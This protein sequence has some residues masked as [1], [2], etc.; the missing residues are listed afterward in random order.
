MKASTRDYY[1]QRLLNVID[2]IHAHLD[3]EL[4]VNTLADIACMSPYHFHRIYRR[5]VQEPV[6]ATVRRL[7]LQRAASE[8]IRSDLSITQIA[9]RVC[10]GSL[11]AFSRAF[12]K[13]FSQSPADY[14]KRHQHK[15]AALEPF[16][17]T[18]PVYKPEEITMYTTEIMEWDALSLVGY[19]HRGDY[20]D[21][22]KAFEKLFVSG[23]SQ[24][25]ISENTR[26]I[27]LYYDDPKSVAIDQLRSMAC[28]TIEPDKSDSVLAKDAELRPMTIP[29][30]RCVSLLFK[31]PYP[32]LE[33]PY[34]WL[35]GEWLPDSGYE[36]AD[37]PPFEEYL[38]DPRE[39]P[40]SELLTR[41]H[42]LLATDS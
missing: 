15:A 14:R 21:I 5:L 36:M 24:G 33:Q 18:L 31:G 13:Q 1:R 3:S 10:Y 38:N 35:F 30:G 34:D 41:I 19:A 16:I 20:L 9:N 4:D 12:I 2:Y 27:G 22:G 7:R 6:N 42:C 40:P 23:I 37:F 28:V 11:E 8:L 32:E 26:S 39:T 17:A 29:A 25:F